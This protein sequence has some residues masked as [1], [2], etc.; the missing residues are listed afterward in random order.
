MRK[1]ETASKA[2]FAFG[3]QLFVRLR[4]LDFILHLTCLLE[5]KGG[6]KIQVTNMF[7][8]GGGT[9]PIRCDSHGNI[10]ICGRCLGK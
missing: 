5:L 4:R 10:Y 8:S 6:D 7:A 3:A 2:T 1:R 9:G